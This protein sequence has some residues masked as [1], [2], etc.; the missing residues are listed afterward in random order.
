MREVIRYSIDLPKEQHVYLM[1][2]SKMSGVKMK[3]LICN[4]LPAPKL[5]LNNDFQKNWSDI[6][7]DTMKEMDPM[8]RS[9]SNR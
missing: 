2:L 9:L 8:L 7:E 4:H 3:D 6:V 5:D 1:T